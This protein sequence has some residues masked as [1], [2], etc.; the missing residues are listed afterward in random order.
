MDEGSR[1]FCPNKQ[2]SKRVLHQ[3]LKYQEVVDIR[4]LGITL[5]TSLFNDKKLTCVSDIYKLTEDDLIPYFL[6]EES[7][8]NEKVSLGAQ[9]VYRSI[10]SHRKMRL[11]TY[12][13]AFDI[14]DVGETSAQ[15]LVQAGFNTLEKLLSATEDQIAGVYGFAEVMAH[16]IVQ[17][18]KENADEMRAL[19]QNGIIEIESEEG[20]KLSGK[21]FCFTGELVKMKRADAEQLVKKKET[22]SF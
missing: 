19:V 18:L 4:D 9:K 6:N 10:Q 3:L 11:A 7:R 1:L 22:S 17:G 20:G 16:T 13:G 5:I 8:E 21:S 12:I 15:K 14:E 2:C